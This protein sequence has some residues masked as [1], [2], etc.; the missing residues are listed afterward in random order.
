MSGPTGISSTSSVFRLKY[1]TSKL[2]CPSESRNHPSYAAV[3]LWLLHGSQPDA[4]VVC[5]EAGREYVAAFPDCLL[6]SIPHLIEHTTVCGSVTNAGIR[7]VGVCINASALQAEER[8]TCLRDLSAL[9]GLPCVDPVATGV[10]PIV[11]YLD[12]HF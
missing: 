9:T 2:T 1:P 12:E 4:F 5:H 10:A 8:D 6:P 11:D 7:C 3:T